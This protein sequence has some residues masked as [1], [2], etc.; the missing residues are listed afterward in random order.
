MV[1]LALAFLAVALLAGLFGFGLISEIVNAAARM[2]V[3]GLLAL[4]Y[5]TR[6]EARVRVE[7]VPD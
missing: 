3:G 2:A 7:A 1:R 5:M 6:L 4:G